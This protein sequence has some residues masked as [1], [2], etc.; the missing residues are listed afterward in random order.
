MEE[1]MEDNDWNT[2]MET[3]MGLNIYVY[4]IYITVYVIYTNIYIYICTY[5]Y[6]HDITCI[7][8]AQIYLWSWVH[9]QSLKLCP[10]LWDPM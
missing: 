5:I 9:A 10:T 7:Q 1:W 6:T 2:L 4:D 8:H 3:D